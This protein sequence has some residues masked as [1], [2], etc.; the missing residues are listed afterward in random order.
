MSRHSQ[1][2]KKLDIRLAGLLQGALI[3]GWHRVKVF[4]RI[5]TVSLITGRVTYQDLEMTAQNDE[6]HDARH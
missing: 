2:V 4:G 5:V 6:N 3:S 1:D